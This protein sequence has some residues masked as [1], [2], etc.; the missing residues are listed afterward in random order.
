MRLRL[1]GARNDLPEIHPNPYRL[2]RVCRGPAAGLRRYCG[3]AGGRS[4]EGDVVMIPNWMLVAGIIVI[5]A[6]YFALGYFWGRGR[7]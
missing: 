2:H 4:H 7:K 5:A 1:G 6:E 3:G